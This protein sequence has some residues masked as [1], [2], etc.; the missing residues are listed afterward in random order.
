LQ[1]FEKYRVFD[2]EAA[3]DVG[4]QVFTM[5]CL[6]LQCKSY[7]PSNSY[8]GIMSTGETDLEQDA[9]ICGLFCHVFEVLDY[10][11]NLLLITLIESIDKAR[12]G[13]LTEGGNC[14]AKEAL[15]NVQGRVSIL[16]LRIN[17]RII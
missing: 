10:V 16:T 14:T 7:S 5:T 17:V 15:K 2:L 11:D 13:V 6:I 9:V 4:R 12:K 1:V 8:I 3:C